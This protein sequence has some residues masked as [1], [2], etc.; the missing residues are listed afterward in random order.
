MP[1]WVL[2]LVSM[3]AGAG[4]VYGAIR[5]DMGRMAARIESHHERLERLED[6]ILY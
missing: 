5:Y 2:Q 1:E 3:F 4:A 6:K